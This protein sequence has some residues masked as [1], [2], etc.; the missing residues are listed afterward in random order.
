MTRSRA[1]RGLIAAGRPI[2]TPTAH[3]ALSAR[4][5]EAMGFSCLA[6]GGSTL[7]AAR[8]ALPDLGLAGFAEMVES[9]RDVVGAVGIPAIVDA[10][11]GYGDVK[12]VVRT[13]H[14]Y[15]EA[16]VAGLILE[17]QVRVAKSP[18]D[19]PAQTVVDVSE[20]VRKLRAAVTHR[21]DA[22]TLV[23]AR[24]DAYATEGLDGVLRRCEAHLAAG[25]D[26]LFVPGVG[27]HEDLAS[28]GAAFPGVYKLIVQTEGSSTPWLA[29]NELYGLGFTQV[30]Y[31]SYLLNRMVAAL[32]QAASEL[33]A[34]ASQSRAPTRLEAAADIR[35]RIETA[36]GTAAW[37]AIEQD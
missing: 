27:R 22:D 24:T 14:A 7:L 23:V 26:G 36:V 21:R 34:A 16:G 31:P 30:A 35:R 29:A 20:M 2:V 37:R 33:D 11:D 3:D 5:L 19:G 32:T 25:A 17:D 8:Y 18:G 6:L 10:D 1:L 15:E 13:V 9:T 28:I 4:L 12:S